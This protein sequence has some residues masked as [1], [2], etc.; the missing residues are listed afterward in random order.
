MPPAKL[1]PA[2]SAGLEFGSQLKDLRTGPP[3][4]KGARLFVYE[5]FLCHLISSTPEG[6]EWKVGWSDGY[7]LF[8]H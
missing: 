4:P 7:V 3:V 5:C 8:I 6:L 2:K 1:G